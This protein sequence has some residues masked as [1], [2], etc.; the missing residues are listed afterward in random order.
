M[1]TLLSAINR[2]GELLGEPKM[3]PLFRIDGCAHACNTHHFTPQ[4]F[5]WLREG[6]R[7]L[8]EQS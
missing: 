2:L 7:E 5:E 1:T 3:P 4:E 8:E 6:E